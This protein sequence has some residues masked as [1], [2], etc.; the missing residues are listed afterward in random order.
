MTARD[1]KLAA[2]ELLLGIG[3]VVCNRFA[4]GDQVCVVES[5]LDVRQVVQSMRPC[6]HNEHL[7]RGV[8]IGETAGNK[9]AA[10][11]TCS[12]IQKSEKVNTSD[13]SINLTSSEDDI[14]LCIGRRHGLKRCRGEG[15]LDELGI[16]AERAAGSGRTPL[17][18]YRPKTR[19]K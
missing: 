12:S 11:S 9:T 4:V 2:T 3:L 8:R 18:L 7:Q 5:W 1:D 19:A 15:V 17:F 16:A 6:L 13:T 14:K 10:G